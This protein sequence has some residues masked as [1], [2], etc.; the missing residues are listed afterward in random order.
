MTF[1]RVSLAVETRSHSM[2]LNVAVVS[3][4]FSAAVTLQGPNRSNADLNAVWAREN[5]NRPTMSP[6]MWRRWVKNKGPF[7]GLALNHTLN[8]TRSM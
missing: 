7:N 4:R 8:H 3:G 2:N 1:S 5:N 6:C